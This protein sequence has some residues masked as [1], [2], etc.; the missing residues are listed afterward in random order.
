M[1]IRGIRPSS[2]VDNLFGFSPVV[3][4][5]G[6]ESEITFNNIKYKIH[7]FT[8]VGS[9]NFRVI[10]SGTDGKV[11]VL[12]VAGG[13]GGGMDMG[14]GGG[15]GGVI[16]TP[17]VIRPGE[18]ILLS[19]GA[20]GLGGPGGSE[21]RSDNAGPNPGSHGFTVSGTNGQNS[22]FGNLTA[23]GGGYGGS[24]YF[25]YGPNLGIGSSGG[26]GGGTSGYSNG[27]VKAGQA[28]TSGQGFKGGQGGGRYYSGGG[29]G[30]GEPGVDSTGTPK[31]GNGVLNNILGY[32]L[33]WGGGGGGS[34]YSAST[35]GNGGIGGGGGG[36]VGTT[37]GGSGYNQGQNG[38]GGSPGSQTNT[39]GGNGGTN[40]GGGGGGGSHYNATNSGGDGGS[41]IVIVRYP[42]QKVTDTYPT[43]NLKL[44]L[45]AGNTASYLGSGTTWTDLSGNENNFTILATAYNSS[46]V[47]YMDFNGSYGCAKKVNSDM[48]IYG[49]VTFVVW[50]RI[51][52]STAEWRTLFRALSSGGDHQVIIESGAYRVGMYDNDKGSGFNTDGYLQTSIPGWNTGQWNM[53]VWRWN[54]GGANY[55]TLSLNGSPQTIVSA[56]TAINSRF[57]TGICSIGAFNNNNQN[58]PSNANQYWGDIAKIYGYNR[59]LTDSEVLQ[60]FNNDRNRFGI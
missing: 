25:D 29:G 4:R 51:K 7:L 56:N 3:A 50:T 34:A 42:L 27:G 22:T 16:S 37:Y 9:D 8:N 59:V 53:L 35:G 6:V 54:P 18:N 1:D 28:G 44:L 57:K 49:P 39:R 31:G 46:G 13:G 60:I 12:V 52:T 48:I 30:T 45:D 38:G 2:K 41:G 55:Y 11:E 33:Y 32:N 26:C 15:G 20:G 19:V 58:D 36:A 43:E 14:G 23:I 5:G 10:D 40:T 47:K 24:S 17:Y 21:R